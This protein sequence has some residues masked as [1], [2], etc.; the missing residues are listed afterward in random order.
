MT[1]PGPPILVVAAA[2]IEREGAFLVTRRLAGAHLEGCWEFPGGK[3]DA[4][5][6]LEACLV[7]EIREELDAAVVVGAEL[8]TIAHEYPGRIVQLHFFR[9]ELRDDP[10]PALGQ[11]MQWAR[12]EDLPRLEFPPA[13]AELIALL[14]AMAPG[15]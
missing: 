6:T 11:A 5:E 2:V 7:R 9:C 1:C 8:F 4:G 13:D 12:R 10:R 3:C 14:T 15:G